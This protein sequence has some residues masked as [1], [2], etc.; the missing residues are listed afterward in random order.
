MKY[1]KHLRK[2][3]NAGTL[4]KRLMNLKVFFN[5]LVIEE[6]YK[7]NKF[8]KNSK[9]KRFEPDFVVLNESQIKAFEN[10][11]VQNGSQQRVRD[12]FIVLLY[13]GLA[14]GDYNELKSLHV[15]NNRIVK[16]RKKTK[17][18]FEV[19]VHPKVSEII[20]RYGDV[21]TLPKIVG[22]AF[23]KQLQ[24]QLKL[25]TE[26]QH[27]EELLVDEDKYETKPF[28]KWVSS[29]CGRHTFIDRLLR[30][31]T[32]Y[33]VLMQFV[34]HKTVDQLISYSKKKGINGE[35]KHFIS[36]L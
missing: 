32:P 33:Q 19:P 27:S 5:H 9:T 35:D 12:I 11:E 36:M 4:R 29:H 34:G 30:L 22:Q 28:Y 14:I 10:F 20:N 16:R 1:E 2:S 18:L 26:F 8:V 7:T 31:Q 25:I 6:G 21:E 23:N 3:L 15:Q 24:N 13:T 17:T